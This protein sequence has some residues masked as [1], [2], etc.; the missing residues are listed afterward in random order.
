MDARLKQRLI[1]AAVLL[2]LIIIVVPMFFSSHE[3]GGTATTSVSL[4]I[5]VQPEP[6]LQSKTLELGAPAPAATAGAAT[7][8][9]GQSPA[10]GRLATV[11][12]PGQP[13]DASSSGALP[14]PAPGMRAAQ[15][16]TPGTSAAPVSTPVPVATVVQP[17]KVTEPLPVGTAAQAGYIISLGVYADMGNA[18]A[19]AA[20]VRKLG[21]K[22]GL[23]PMVRGY[24]PMVRVYAGPFPNRAL[25]EAARLRIHAH[26]PH[27]A[28]AVVSSPSNL[29]ADQPAAALPAGQPGGWVVQLGAFDKEAVASALKDRALAAGFPAYTDAMRTAQGVALWRVRVGPEA[30]RSAAETLR[31]QLKTQLGQDGIVTVVQ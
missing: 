26:E 15:A 1:G 25:A 7:A 19:L 22:A 16:Q 30:S 24:M 2:A 28:A 3:Q 14:R 17:K 9:S 10:A 21:I 23:Q 8:A 31:A 11:T 4:G 27:T 20:R 6:P 12:I 29:G 5:P 18:R 13:A